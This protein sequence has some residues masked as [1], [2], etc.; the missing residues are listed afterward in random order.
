MLEEAD[1]TALLRAAANE[2]YIRLAATRALK[3]YEQCMP[4]LERERV[5][6]QAFSSDQQCWRNC[7]ELAPTA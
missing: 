5:S 6:E 7:D 4:S 3:E 1:L 2:S